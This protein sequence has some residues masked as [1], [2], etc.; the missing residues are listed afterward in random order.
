[1]RWNSLKAKRNSGVELFR[2]IAMLMII[3]L[4]YFETADANTYVVGNSVSGYVYGV[5]SSSC[6]CGVNMF[7]LITGYFSI[8]S[9][10]IK[11]RKIINLLCDMAIWGGCW[12][13][14]INTNL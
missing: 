5:F 14:T 9:Y 3:T 7:V 10:S 8:N 11:W 13:S 1:M 12:S 6:I 4:H 2:I